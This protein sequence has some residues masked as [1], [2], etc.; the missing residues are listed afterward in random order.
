LAKGSVRSRHSQVNVIAERCK[1]CS[2]CIEFCP[3]H[4]LYKS[5]EINSKGYHIVDVADNDKCDGCNTCSMICPDFA[6]SAVSAEEEPEK[7][8]R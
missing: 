5:T 7:R 4:V 2:F 8:Q 1:G 6:I 3:E